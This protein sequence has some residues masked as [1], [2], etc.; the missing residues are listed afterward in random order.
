MKKDTDPNVATLDFVNPKAS[1][2]K[3]GG[4]LRKTHIDEW[5]QL[6][7]ILVGHMSF[8]GPRPAL[9]NQDNLIKERDAVN[10]NTLT[11]GLT[12]LAQVSMKDVQFSDKEKAELDGVY[13]KKMSLWLDIK[14]VFQTFFNLFK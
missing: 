2:T 7:N 12:G 8:V 4:F 14:I 1:Y 3:C 13:V 11:P 10:A 6:L 9:W 5:P